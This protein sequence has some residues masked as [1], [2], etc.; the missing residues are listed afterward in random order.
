MSIFDEI[1]DDVD[2]MDDAVRDLWDEVDD[3]F[4]DY[5]DALW[6]RDQVAVSAANRDIA[7]L[8]TQRDIDQ[9][10]ARRLEDQVDAYLQA[11]GH[12]PYFESLPDDKRPSEM[13]EH[14]DIE[15]EGL[16][17]KIGYTFLGG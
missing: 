16:L 17:E 1:E 12:A 8:Y 2:E 10:Q 13:Y 9:F 5:E 7:L 6:K 11:A 15:P 14:E 3:V 4:D